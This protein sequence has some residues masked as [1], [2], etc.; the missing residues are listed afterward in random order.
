MGVYTVK[1]AFDLNQCALLNRLPSRANL[2]RRHVISDLGD[3]GCV[4]CEDL[5]ETEPHLFLSC[6]F[7]EQDFV[8]SL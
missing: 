5:L 6:E 3:I 2:F 8:P 4:H 1:S 7:S